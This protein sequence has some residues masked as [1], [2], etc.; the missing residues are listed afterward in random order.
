MAVATAGSLLKEAREARGLSLE[1][2][3]AAT[4]VR[5]PYLEALEHDEVH[6]LPAPVY[7]RG[8]L[9]AYASL[10]ELE[11]EPLVAS[12]RP[13]SREPERIV[14][15]RERSLVPAW[16][17]TL[18]P[19]LLLGGAVV[20]L[21]G[22]FLLYAKH[23]LNSLKPAAAK[24]PAVLIAHQ[25]A[26][27]TTTVRSAPP[28]PAASSADA[29]TSGPPDQP[30]RRATG[31]VAAGE[32]VVRLHFTDAVWA[33][34]VVDGTPVYGANGNF[35]NA[36]DTVSWTGA[37]ISVTTGKGAATLVTVDGRSQGA[38]PDGVT[39]KEYRAQT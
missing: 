8:Y 34:V 17:P 29:S 12:L 36:G 6:R 2:V 18:S 19:T 5:V 38:L 32:I 25:A 31:Q 3:A 35:F 21:G 10:L 16:R 7:A 14:T 11:P 22:I 26:T 13:A 33:Y 15:P 24:P 9:R 28:A 1:E 27:S 20:V 4:R 30:G 23:E 37:D 39:T